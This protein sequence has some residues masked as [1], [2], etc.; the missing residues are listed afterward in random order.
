MF[1]GMHKA[2]GHKDMSRIFSFSPNFAFGISLAVCVALSAIASAHAADLQNEDAPSWHILKRDA[3]GRPMLVDEGGKKLKILETVSPDAASP[4][5]EEIKEIDPTKTM[6][7]Q[8]LLIDPP[9]K[10][11][12]ELKNDG[13]EILEQMR[14]RSL[15]AEVW[16][17]SIPSTMTEKGALRILTKRYPKLIIDTNQ[18]FD[19]SA[20]K[21]GPDFSRGFVGWGPVASSCGAGMRIGMIDGA[22]NTKIEALRKQRVKFKAFNAKDRKPA[23]TAHG[24]AV[25]AM[26]VGRPEGDKENIGG[27]LPG[28]NLFAAGI[29]EIRAGKEVGNLG[30]MLKAADWLLKSRVAVV[31]MSIAGS[32]NGV[33]TF[34]LNKLIESGVTVV[35]AAGNNGPRAKPA[36]PAAHPKVIAVTAIDNKLKIYKQ[37]NQGNYVDFSAPGVNL[38]TQV[39]TGLKLQSGTSFASPFIAAMVAIHLDAGFPS[40]ADQLRGSLRRYTKDLGKKGRDSAFGWGLVRLKPSCG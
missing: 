6:R 21:V 4:G 28:A 17:I 20:G 9:R 16:R 5:P 33:M 27:L 15:K 25:A 39:P 7:G 3:Q 2:R 29:F 19:L 32:G 1:G 34:V 23:G 8:L 14:L 24:T 31:N 37:A 26:L 12:K 18:I 10:L 22:V 13:F 36:W 11:A 40:D 35:A 38:M 30:N